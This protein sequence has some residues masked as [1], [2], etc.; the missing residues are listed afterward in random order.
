[1]KAEKVIETFTKL[2]HGFGFKDLEV[3]EAP[4]NEYDVEGAY[5]VGFNSQHGF[6]MDIDIVPGEVEVKVGPSIL[7]PEGGTEKVKGY[8]VTGYKPTMGNREEPPDVED[9]VIAEETR[10]Q[11]AF[12]AGINYYLQN[13]IGNA[14]E[15][16]SY[17]EMAEE[18]ERMRKEGL[19]NF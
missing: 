8:I 11:N 17:E 2:M 10:L 9:F 7:N 6:T 1:M 18:E 19:D 13:A 12:N 5:M 15:S 16:A 14:W 4:P 3:K